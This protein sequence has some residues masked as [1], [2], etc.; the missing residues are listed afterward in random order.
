ML[1]CM[2]SGCGDASATLVVLSDTTAAAPSRVVVALPFDPA[3]LPI[4]PET[5]VPEG[6]RG[7][8]VRL[9][10]SRHDSSSRADAAFQTVR[11]AA[12]EAASELATLDRTS[13]EYERRYE[14][15]RSLADSAESLRT[16]RDRLRQRFEAI[17]DRLGPAARDVGSNGRRVRTRESVDSAA[18]SADRE[19]VFATLR[20]GEGRLLLSPGEWW[21]VRASAESVLLP[22]H[23]IELASGAVDT[24]SLLPSP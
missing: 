13:A 2:A 5:R 11:T 19:P 21:L 24:I 20:D 18:R 12:N 17:I 22:A 23:R 3:H 14:A 10:L 6:P 9:A 7:D 8:S 16:S 4:V 15:W 1:G